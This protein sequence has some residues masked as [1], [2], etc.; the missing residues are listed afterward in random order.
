M[1]NNYV[2]TETNFLLTLYSIKQLFKTFNLYVVQ[3]TLEVENGL[4][5]YTAKAT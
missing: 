1:C 2:Y 5:T 3:I 4:L